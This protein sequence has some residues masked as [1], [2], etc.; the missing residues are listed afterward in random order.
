[1]LLAY[2]GGVHQIEPQHIEEAW[3][4]LQQ[5]PAPMSAEPAAEKADSVIEFGGLDDEPGDKVASGASDEVAE[6][7]ASEPDISEPIGESDRDLD[8]AEQVRHIQ[9]ILADVEEEFQ[10]A[11]SI[12]PEVELSFDD[13][14]PFREKFAE[15]EVVA[16]RYGPPAEA[17]SLPCDPPQA[18][19]PAPPLQEVVAESTVPPSV[20][21]HQESREAR[22]QP[23]AR[24][25]IDLEKAF[26]N[27]QSWPA[28]SVGAIDRPHF[29]QLFARLRHGF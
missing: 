6:A 21:M 24:G 12:G 19:E 22:V 27:R 11:G 8:P 20:P 9:Q 18:A 23:T 15:E 4:D 13:A 29:G 26:Q 16:D 3:A 17:A 2:A 7:P 10:P 14:H 1:M 25:G 5:L 28:Q